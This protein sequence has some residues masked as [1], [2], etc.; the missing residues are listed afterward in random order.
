MFFGLVDLTLSH[1]CVFVGASFDTVGVGAEAIEKTDVLLG[2][3]LKDRAFI[4]LKFEREEPSQEE[5]VSEPANMSTSTGKHGLGL[6]YI[7]FGFVALFNT[8]YNLQLL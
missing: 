5:E 1:F 7:L 4:G 8:K 6:V 2:V 3:P